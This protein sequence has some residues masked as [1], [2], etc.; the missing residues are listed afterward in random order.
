MGKSYI[1]HS[2]LCGCE[3]CARSADGSGAPV[4]DVVDDPDIRECG[5]SVFVSCDCED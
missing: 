1:Q 5:C 2:D 3:R 4:F